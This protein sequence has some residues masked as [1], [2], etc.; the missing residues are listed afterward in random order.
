MSSLFARHFVAPKAMFTFDQSTIFS[1]FLAEFLFNS[2][3]APLCEKREP[4]P[5]DETLLFASKLW[6]DNLAFGL[7]LCR[8]L[9]I[10]SPAFCWPAVFVVVY[11]PSKQIR[12]LWNSSQ[13]TEIRNAAMENVEKLRQC[14]Q[15]VQKA[16]EM[17]Y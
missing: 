8:S 5:G 13:P 17:R 3:I 1:R 4:I 15:R 11:V 9:S 10:Y 2:T 12:M 14:E 16:E 6:N 7:L